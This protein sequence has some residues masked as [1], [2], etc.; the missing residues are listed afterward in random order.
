[1]PV[2]YYTPQEFFGRPLTNTDFDATLQ[3]DL[4][5]AQAFIPLDIAALR[6]IATNDITAG[7][8]GGVLALD[9]A[10]TLKRLATSTDKCLRVT[11]AAGSSIEVQF[12]PVPWSPDLNPDADVIVH[13]LIARNGTTD[14]CI[15][16]VQA[17]ETTV[18]GSAYAGDTEMG[19]NTAALS[20]AAN[21]IVEATV[22]L[23]A[24][25]IVGHPGVLNLA[26]VPAAHT[27][28]ILYLY[29]GWIEYTRALRTT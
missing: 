1:M 21:V 19:G 10:P 7:A 4:K 3:A 26:L 13:L 6:L 15:I 18:T 9:S 20:A 23:A 27:T 29:A 17:F 2:T 24:A 12:P 28:N 11:W 22:T 16:D 14:G 8:G 25:D 5:S